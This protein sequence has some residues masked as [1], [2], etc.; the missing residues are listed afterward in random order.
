MQA[1]CEEARAGPAAKKTFGSRLRGR[2]V[3]ACPPIEEGRRN[4]VLHIGSV[5]DNMQ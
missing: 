4:G 3:L 5:D 2:L 1:A